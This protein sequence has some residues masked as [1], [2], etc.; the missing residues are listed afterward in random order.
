MVLNTGSV[1]PVLHLFPALQTFYWLLWTGF[2]SRP[3]MPSPL[4]AC[5]KEKK[6][7]LLLQ[8]LPVLNPKLTSG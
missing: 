7:L 5:P 1:F 8:C 4:T 3:F 2:A 6:L